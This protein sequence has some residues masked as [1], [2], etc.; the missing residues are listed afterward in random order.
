MISVC[1]TYHTPG[2]SPLALPAGIRALAHHNY[3][4]GR[5]PLFRP[6]VSAQAERWDGG[7]DGVCINH[8]PRE[9]LPDLAEWVRLLRRVWSPGLGGEIVAY[10]ADPGVNQFIDKPVGTIAMALRRP[11]LVG[12]TGPQEWARLGYDGYKRPTDTKLQDFKD[13][14]RY[15]IDRLR[16]YGAITRKPGVWFIDV[17]D[18]W[19]KDAYT[20]PTIHA[21]QWV[22]AQIE[23]CP[24][25][26]DMCIYAG[27]NED[28][29]RTI[30]DRAVMRALGWIMERRS[31]WKATGLS[32]VKDGVTS[33]ALAGSLGWSVS[34]LGRA[35]SSRS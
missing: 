31:E 21:D 15:R 7:L 35:L 4:E 17:Q 27:A 26:V 2:R 11:R 23:A 1:Y 10:G 29:A 6:I 24:A 18:Q 32:S 3:G 20:K 33:G 5:L 22:L 9:R 12:Y 8:E 14:L 19:A 25:T 34:S 16:Q 13:R 30:V 28:S